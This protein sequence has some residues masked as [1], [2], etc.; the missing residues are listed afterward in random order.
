MAESKEEMVER[1]TAQVESLRK[2]IDAAE[3]SQA[4]ARAAERARNDALENRRERE[5][6]IEGQRTA[7]LNCRE[8][9]AR[10]DAILEPF[11]R[12]APRAMPLESSADYRRRCANEV[13][14]RLSA[15]NPL[16]KVDFMALPDAA[17]FNLERQCYA[18]AEKA[19][20]SNDSVPAGVIEARSTIGNDGMRQTNFYGRESFVVGMG[21]QS[22][23]AILVTPGEIAAKKMAGIW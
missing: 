8:Y 19:A 11:G 20:I 6:L 23:R 7:D 10:A 2:S 4:A 12:T 3:K 13:A 18:D 15:D 14:M 9:Q 21:R 1:L 16:R 17:F 5:R 22:R